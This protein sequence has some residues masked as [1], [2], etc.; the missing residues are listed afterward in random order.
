MRVVFVLACV[1][2]VFSARQKNMKRGLVV[3]IYKNLRLTKEKKV[4][5]AMTFCGISQLEANE[6]AKEMSFP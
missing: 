4:F 3:V 1:G 5:L 6:I 2:S